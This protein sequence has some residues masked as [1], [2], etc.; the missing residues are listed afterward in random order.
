MAPRR[1]DL[2]EGFAMPFQNDVKRLSIM[3]TLAGEESLGQ[4]LDMTNFYLHSS[5]SPRGIRI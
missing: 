4:V 5:S 2:A 3:S 1:R